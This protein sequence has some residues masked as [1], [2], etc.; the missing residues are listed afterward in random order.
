MHEAALRIPGSVERGQSARRRDLR[1]ESAE[2]RETREVPRKVSLPISAAGGRRP[3]SSGAVSRQWID[4]EAYSLRDRPRRQD[5]LRQA[6][7]AQA[8]G[9]LDGVRVIRLPRVYPILDSDAADRR[10]ISIEAAAAAFLDG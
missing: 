3:E 8:G 2:R 9:G 4:R 1:R 7:H 10:G 5:P 6:G